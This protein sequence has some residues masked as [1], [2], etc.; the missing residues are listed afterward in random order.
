MIGKQTQDDKEF[1]VEDSDPLVK[2]TLSEVTCEYNYSNPT[3]FF[4][5]SIPHI[6][7][8]TNM[9]TTMSYAQWK[10]NNWET[11]KKQ[12]LDELKA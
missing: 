8:K 2:V 6:E 10:K 4:N 12:K 1:M 5:L 3:G 11:Q 9:Y 7:F